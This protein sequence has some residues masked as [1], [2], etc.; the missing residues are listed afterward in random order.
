MLGSSS[1]TSLCLAFVRFLA[2]CLSLLALSLCPTELLLA[3]ELGFGTSQHLLLERKRH[4]ETSKREGDET[5]LSL[6]L[7]G[8]SGRPRAKPQDQPVQLYVNYWS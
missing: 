6:P 8:H 2:A 4:M 7:E 5:V 1:C 3:N